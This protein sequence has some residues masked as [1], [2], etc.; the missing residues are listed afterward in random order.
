MIRWLQE[1]KFKDWR[2]NC[3]NQN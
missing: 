1:N 3:S 2:N